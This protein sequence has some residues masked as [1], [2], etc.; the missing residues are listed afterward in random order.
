MKD[1]IAKLE[2][3][4]GP[5]GELEAV[6]WLAV[7]PGATRH[8]WSYTHT[9]TGRV[10]EVDETRDKFGHLISVPRYMES[11]DAARNLIPNDCTFAVGD[12]GEDG[13]SWACVTRGSTDYAAS[14]AT[15]E[16]AL[17]IAA[18]RARDGRG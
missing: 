3:A 6:I 12:C 5:D 17:C 15:P 2:A 4:A 9:A 1:L 13:N 14:A 10:C 7:T 11:L 8:K 16:L 18:L